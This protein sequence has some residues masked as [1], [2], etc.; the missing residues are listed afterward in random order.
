MS[1]TSGS[2]VSRSGVVPASAAA[3]STSCATQTRPSS[4]YQAGIWCPHQSW[5]EMHQGR[6]PSSQCSQVFSQDSGMSRKSPLRDASSARAAIPETSQNHCVET[7]GSIGSPPRWL[8]PTL[9]T[10]SSTLTSSPSSTRRLTTPSRA[11]K[12]SRPANSAPASGL[13]RPWRSMTVTPGRPWRRASS[14]SNGS[15]NGVTLT[16]PLPN[17]GSTAGSGTKGSRRPTSGST[18][19]RP[20]R[21]R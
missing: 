2:W 20:E 3:S 17:S 6:I 21:W 10:W 5:R 8:W 9:W 11:S 16:R 13:M 19:C 7:S 12:R 1:R 18:A 4:S 14:K 15:W